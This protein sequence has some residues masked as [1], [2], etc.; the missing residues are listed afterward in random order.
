MAVSLKKKNL[1][2]HLDGRGFAGSSTERFNELHDPLS[3][4]S[5]VMLFYDNFCIWPHM[6]MHWKW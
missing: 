1:V 5:E 3:L 2:F 6:Y 4:C